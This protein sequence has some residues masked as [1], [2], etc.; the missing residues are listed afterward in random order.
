MCVVPLQTRMPGVLCVMMV[1]GKR[2]QLRCTTMVDSHVH[3]LWRSSI[4]ECYRSAMG[5]VC[6]RRRS[7]NAAC[8]IALAV[9]QAA[10]HAPFP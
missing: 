10:S 5:M 3:A 2:K 7:W 9:D 1:G 6:V 8:L 4:L